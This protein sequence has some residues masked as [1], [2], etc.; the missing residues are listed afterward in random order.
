MNTARAKALAKAMFRGEGAPVLP[1]RGPA[2]PLTQMLD[3]LRGLTDE[4]WARYAFSREPLERKFSGEQ[5]QSLARRAR[6]C[7]AQWARRATEEYHTENPRALAAAMAL[8]VRT[9][10]MPAGGGPVIFAQF[11]KPNEITVYT[12]CIEKAREAAPGE[13]V[14]GERLFDTLLAHEIFHY[15][16]ETHERE[17]FTRTEKIELWKKPFSNRSPILCLGEIAGMAFAKELLRLPYSPYL[18]DVLLTYGYD[19]RAASDL[20]REILELADARGSQN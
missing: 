19:G 11:V 20:Y 17:I 18:L 4:Q 6:E 5:K 14:H 15:I 8:E 12:D 16:E 9:P 1:E 3:T 2:L 13:Y 10:G 7:G